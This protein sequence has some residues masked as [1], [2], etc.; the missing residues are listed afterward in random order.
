MLTVKSTATRLMPPA[1]FHRARSLSMT[2]A[3]TNDWTLAKVHWSVVLRSL[4]GYSSNRGPW[5]K[6]RTQC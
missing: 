2:M 5:D 6:E 4:D 3:M 1:S